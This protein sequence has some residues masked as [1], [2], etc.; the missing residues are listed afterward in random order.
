MTSR[1]L[2]A[3][4]LLG[5]LWFAETSGLALLYLFIADPA[6]STGGVSLVVLVLIG[7]SIG[8]RWAL[9]PRCKTLSYLIIAYIAGLVAAQAAGLYSIF[10][11]RGFIT[12]SVVAALLC[13][14]MY[15]PVFRI[16]SAEPPDR[17]P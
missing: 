15:I 17:N 12:E 4:L 11:G 8:V 16:P 10:L 5:A 3:K 9:L 6:K 2:V 14:L 13:L 1:D 7:L